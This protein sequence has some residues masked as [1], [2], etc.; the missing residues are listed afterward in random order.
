MVVV[1]DIVIGYVAV[2]VLCYFLLKYISVFRPY[3]FN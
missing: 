1:A 2:V 3:L